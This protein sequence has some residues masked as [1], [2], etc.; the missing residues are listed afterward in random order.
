MISTLRLF[1]GLFVLVG[2]LVSLF[3]MLYF[4]VFDLPIVATISLVFIFIF[5]GVSQLFVKWEKYL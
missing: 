4:I 2:F 1:L 3:S 5:V